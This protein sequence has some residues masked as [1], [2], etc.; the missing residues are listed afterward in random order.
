MATVAALRP[1]TPPPKMTTRP[2]RVPG[3]PP[4]ST[5]LPPRSVVQLNGLVGDRDD[6]AA[7][8]LAR[9]C[10]LCR[11]MQV[12][13]ENEPVPKIAI[14]G[15]LRL[16][17]LDDHF[18][19]PRVARRLHDGR[20]RLPVF[21]LANAAPL[22]RPLLD[23]HRVAPLEKLPDAAR[24]HAHSVLSRFDLFGYADDHEFLLG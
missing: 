1:T 24:R 12:R 3:T 5:P 9:Q 16:L 15:G 4:R 19:S 7:R 18:R 11:K 21:L 17:H 13:V 8:E 23:E 6:A 10:R 20:A 2:R 22:A 14:F